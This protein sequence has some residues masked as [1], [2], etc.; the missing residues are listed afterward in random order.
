MMTLGTAGV[1]S[2]FEILA[3]DS[4]GNA[5]DSVQH[6][7]GQQ[8]AAT[9]VQWAITTQS[10]AVHGEAGA[11]DEDGLYLGRIT[12]KVASPSADAQSSQASSHLAQSAPAQSCRLLP[13]LLSIFLL[14][15]GG[16]AATYYTGSGQPL[17]PLTATSST[18][19]GTPGG[20]GGGGG[21]GV[22]PTMLETPFR[23]PYVPSRAVE[24]E[25]L[26]GQ[27]NTYVLRWSGFIRPQLAGVYTFATR[28][29]AASPSFP[30]ASSSPG[31]AGRGVKLW[32]DGALILDQLNASAGLTGVTN[33]FNRDT[34][35][36]LMMELHDRYDTGNVSTVS[37]LT[38]FL[39]SI[40][41]T[42]ASATLV[43]SSRLFSGEQIGGSPYKMEVQPAHVCAARSAFSTQHHVPSETF[44]LSLVTA[45]QAAQFFVTARDA[46]SNRLWH[47]S[48]LNASLALSG[49]GGAAGSVATR[50]ATLG[51]GVG[52]FGVDSALAYVSP[53]TAADVGQAPPAPA[54]DA[55]GALSSTAGIFK[56]R[57]TLTRSGTYDI[58]VTFGGSLVKGSPFRISVQ[59]G[60]R[61]LPSSGISG[62]GLTLATAGLVSWLTLT[63]RDQHLN[64]RPDPLI[65]EAGINVLVEDEARRL[66]PTSSLPLAPHHFP[67]FHDTAVSTSRDKATLSINYILTR[68]GHYSM[69][70][71]GRGLHE[72]EVAAG[73]FSLHVAP[74]G[75]CACASRVTLP[76]ALSVATAGVPVSLTI[77]SRD[78][79][80]N[81]R[82]PPEH[83]VSNSTI[84]RH[85][86][87]SAAYSVILR[88][89]PANAPVSPL[90]CAGQGAGLA[91]N[92]GCLNDTVGWTGDDHAAV[93]DQPGSLTA[94][95]TTYSQVLRASVMGTRADTATTLWVRLAHAGG[96]RASFFEGVS[97]FT[98]SLECCATPCA[99]ASGS[100]PYIQHEHAY[101]E[102]S[103][104]HAL[105]ANASAPRG[106]SVR[107][108]G[109]LRPSVAGVYTFTMGRG[110]Y[111]YGGERVRLWLDNLLILDQWSSLSNF[112][113]SSF[114]SG[115]QARAAVP[116]VTVSLRANS[117]HD[118]RI[119][120]KENLDDLPANL[121]NSSVQLLWKGPLCNQS[122]AALNAS[123]EHLERCRF[124]RIP[125]SMLHSSTHV[126]GSPVTLPTSPSAFCATLSTVHGSALTI[127]TAG[128]PATF[129]MRT[130]DEFGNV[131][132]LQ[133][134]QDTHS[135]DF[136]VVAW[137]SLPALKHLQ[138]HESLL[139]QDG[140]GTRANASGFTQCKTEYL[141]DGVY[142]ISYLPVSSGRYQIRGRTLQ[143]GGLYGTYFENSDLSDH[144]VSPDGSSAAS[145]PSFARLDRQVDFNWH[146]SQRPCG[147]PAQINKDIG[148]DYFSARWQGL[149]LPAFS[150]TWTFHVRLPPG[151]DV[152]VRVNG[153]L[154]L[155]S[156]SSAASH[157]SVDGGGKPAW[158]E[159]SRDQRGRE[160]SMA[161][162][163][164]LMAEVAYPITVEYRRYIAPGRLQL[165]WQHRSLVSPTVDN[166]LPIPS[167]RL[168]TW[169]TP[170]SL[171]GSRLSLV[172]N[173][174]HACAAKSTLSGSLLSWATAG[175]SAAFMITSRDE[176]SNLRSGPDGGIGG[177]EWSLLETRSSGHLAAVESSSKFTLASASPRKADQFNG[178]IIR[179]HRLREQRRVKSYSTMQIAVLTAGFSEL[180]RVGDSYTI[181]DDTALSDQKR[182]EFDMGQPRYY[183]RFAPSPRSGLPG[184]GPRRSVHV[185]PERLSSHIQAGGLSATYYA[186]DAEFA[187]KRPL[188]TT[189][190]IIGGA[191]D[192]TVDFSV[193]PIRGSRQRLYLDGAGNGGGMAYS[194]PRSSGFS[195]RWKGSISVTRPGIYSFSTA[196]NS[197]PDHHVRLWIDG[198]RMV[199]SI[200]GVSNASMLFSK[201]LPTI[202]PLELH[203]TSR[204]ANNDSA[205]RL[206]WKPPD[207]DVGTLVASNASA[208]TSFKIVQ[209]SNLHPLSGQHGVRLLPTVAGQYRLHVGIAAVGGLDA[210]FYSDLD[211]QNAVSTCTSQTMQLNLEENLLSDACTSVTKEGSGITTERPSLSPR[212][213]SVRWQGLLR[214]G[215]PDLPNM[216]S[217]QESMFSFIAVV[218]HE[219]SERVRLWVDE[220][221][222]I[223]AWDDPPDSDPAIDFVPPRGSISLRGGF[224]YHIRLE[225]S[226]QAAEGERPASVPLHAVSG[227]HMALEWLSPQGA[228]GVRQTCASETATSIDAG[229]L[230]GS[231]P[232]SS[233]PRQE[234]ED[235][236]DKPYSTM[237]VFAHR[238]C[239]SGWDFLSINV[240]D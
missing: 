196:T 205:I 184:D 237:T 114:Q 190:C 104:Q 232:S 27:N 72:G 158:R 133:A 36:P 160:I 210:T 110:N 116:S 123:S 228:Q 12:P 222:L 38:L 221:L 53:L 152:K 137:G 84:V 17:V 214:V 15:P 129:T 2:S 76:A 57:Y 201:A 194:L 1:E 19:K 58:R 182:K 87:E 147:T 230:F 97:A 75:L 88:T 81:V 37:N 78:Q 44:V 8:G 16:M 82:A 89:G 183:A 64:L 212:A 92:L 120:W 31:V 170:A 204:S 98:P 80:G 107:W 83:Q 99:A 172:V 215:E 96:V 189:E 138:P 162:T 234:H 113:F 61:H 198:A 86:G 161:G 159:Q 142:G 178:M 125:L 148:P 94:S 85:P 23:P 45:G 155:T 73:P 154:V 130:R 74:H 105:Q 136:A 77:L 18:A 121:E 106:F 60:R 143:A 169:T 175:V 51:L 70:V 69:R 240:S 46:Y 108:E 10:Q 174:A 157:A 165:Q 216:E 4:F 124:Q 47:L 95:A 71:A 227:H 5:C 164:A 177:S 217:G 102:A 229:C 39:D 224:Y 220:E 115:A 153:L 111:A 118:M 131:R 140:S 52:I 41:G 35:L 26:R 63:V 50:G 186:L 193:S 55:C 3:R 144:G 231:R 209:P 208:P 122:A 25:A 91:T 151:N 150:G 146:K 112:S 167:S 32:V 219:S 223:D 119:G 6:R 213:F 218:A 11:L 236:M 56:V 90:Q 200:G 93:A 54:A 13:S 59:P 166:K 156:S 66:I 207:D 149:V 163:V 235:D 192:A 139:L 206:L 132:R 103:W 21:G 40:R 202:Y 28:V 134:G 117:Y 24:R 49:T 29:Q 42:D 135:I 173:A 7:D 180:P 188:W 195:V 67:A 128:V 145:V 34:P 191:C 197:A 238:T 20:G 179:L 48:S 65:A 43:A 30:A 101:V 9:P 62:A 199:D 226:H 187:G 127:A 33:V 100:R 22:T 211:L 14:E 141:G 203:Y 225:Y 168:L 233:T 79:Y 239:A 171:C 68:S 109:M 181:V 176:F 126:E 185:L